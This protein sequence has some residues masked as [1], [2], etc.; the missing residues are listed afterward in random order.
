ML[1]PI[2]TFSVAIVP[3]ETELGSAG[4]FVSF[5]VCLL[6]FSSWSDGRLK[7]YFVQMK[8]THRNRTGLDNVNS[9]EQGFVWFRVCC[10]QSIC[11][12]QAL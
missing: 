3:D 9:A 1:A 6:A 4:P 5:P 10:R 8:L 2:F 11:V 12:Q 7:I